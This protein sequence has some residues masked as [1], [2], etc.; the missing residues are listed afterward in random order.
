MHWLGTVGEFHRHILVS[1]NL[2]SGSAFRPRGWGVAWFF[3][4]HIAESLVEPA[5]EP[6]WVPIDTSPDARRPGQCSVRNPVVDRTFRH[7]EYFSRFFFR[8]GLVGR[9]HLFSVRGKEQYRSV[10]VISE[11]LSSA[12]GSVGTNRSSSPFLP[13]EIA[14]RRHQGASPT[15]WFLFFQ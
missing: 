2:R 13:S 12:P 7:F 8:Y 4:R 15:R 11:R 5:I 9:M 14:S 6:D 10:S 3:C 1:T